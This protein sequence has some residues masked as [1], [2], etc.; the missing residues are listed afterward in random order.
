[1]NHD[2]NLF[3]PYKLGN[4][5]LPNRMVM[6]PLTRNRAGEGNVPGTLNVTYYVQRASAG[7]IIAEATQVSPQGLGYPSTPGIHSPEQVAG[8]KQVNGCRA[9][10]RWENFLATVACRTDFSS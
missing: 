10:A 6:A 5:E 2:I 9:S 4:L 8:W 3:S 1:M 7:L